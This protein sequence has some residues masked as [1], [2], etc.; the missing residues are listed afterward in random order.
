MS[1]R[2]DFLPRSVVHE[3]FKPHYDQFGKGVR[4]KHRDSRDQNV[5][6]RGHEKKVQDTEF[7]LIFKGGKFVL[8][9][10]HRKVISLKQQSGAS[11]ASSSRKRKRAPHEKTN[12]PGDHS[13]FQNKRRKEERSSTKVLHNAPMSHKKSGEDVG[14]NP[15]KGNCV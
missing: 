10:L 6:F 3:E 12:M 1:L 13:M 11:L 2:Y 5:H 8:E 9:K 15:K 14:E 4:V 7:V